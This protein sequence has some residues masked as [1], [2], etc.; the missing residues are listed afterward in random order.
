MRW[1]PPRAGPSFSNLGISMPSRIRLTVA[2]AGLIALFSTAVAGAT[3]LAPTAP[4]TFPDGNT[5]SLDEMKTGQA[6]VKDFVTQANAYID[7][8]DSEKPKVD[9]KKKM[10]E[11]EAADMKAAQDAAEKKIQAEEAEK[12]TVA[13]RFNDQVKAFKAKAAAAAEPPKN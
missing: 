11:K 2:S 4:G 13:Q 10:S 9:P 3:C 6:S 8:V 7:C 1:F 12:A 5:A